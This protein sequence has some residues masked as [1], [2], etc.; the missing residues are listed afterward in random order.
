MATLGGRNF[1]LVLKPL[2]NQSP[3]KVSPPPPPQ[4]DD[5]KPINL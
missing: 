3:S 5:I 2:I 4:G 1:F